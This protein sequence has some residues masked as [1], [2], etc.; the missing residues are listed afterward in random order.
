MEISIHSNG[1]LLSE[2]KINF[3]KKYKVHI[4]VSL[5]GPK[6]VQDINRKFRNETSSF[7]MVYSKIKLL[8]EK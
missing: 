7:E 5:D 2:D 1:I 8:K 6:H 3:L 4:L